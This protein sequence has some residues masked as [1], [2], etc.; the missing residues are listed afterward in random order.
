MAIC[1]TGLATV[2]FV[3][4]VRQL[5]T[6]CVRDAYD[7]QTCHIKR[8]TFQTKLPQKLGLAASYKNAASTLKIL[9]PLF[10]ILFFLLLFFFLQMFPLPVNHATMS[11]ESKEDKNNPLFMRV[12]YLLFAPFSLQLKNRKRYHRFALYKSVTF[13]HLHLQKSFMVRT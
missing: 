1:F 9:V 7:R 10:V 13:R 11:H 3:L 6:R 8:Q 5:S 12:F 2:F 4:N